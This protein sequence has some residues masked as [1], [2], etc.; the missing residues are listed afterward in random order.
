VY[1]V[2]LLAE[3]TTEIATFQDSVNTLGVDAAAKEIANA[4]G[5]KSTQTES[6]GPLGGTMLCGTLSENSVDVYA[7]EW[8]DQMS[9]GWVYFMPS[10]SHGRA[11]G[12]TLDLRGASE[13]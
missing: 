5:M 3:D 6:A 2:W 12:Y 7:C 9:F 8:L 1:S 13:K 11:L 4:A 10:V